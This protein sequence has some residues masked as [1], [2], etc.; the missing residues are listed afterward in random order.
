MNGGMFREEAL[1]AGRQAG[2]AGQPV[3]P[4]IVMSPGRRFDIRGLSGN[5]HT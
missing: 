2:T 3:L 5:A 1:P 4:V